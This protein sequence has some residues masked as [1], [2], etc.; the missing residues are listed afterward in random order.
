MHFDIMYIIRTYFKFKRISSFKVGY[1][2]SVKEDQTAELHQN[3]HERVLVF[4][5]SQLL[6]MAVKHIVRSC[7]MWSPLQETINNSALWGVTSWILEEI[8]WWVG[9]T[10]CFLFHPQDWGKN[11]R[12]K[13]GKFWQLTRCHNLEYSSLQKTFVFVH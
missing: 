6:C 3:I 11:S 7:R 2:V 9:G 12:P 13:L 5:L 10:Y 1:I 4:C 8:Y